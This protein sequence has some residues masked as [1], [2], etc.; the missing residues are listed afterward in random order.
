MII[1]LVRHV[2]DGVVLERTDVPVTFDGGQAQEG[3]VVTF[4]LDGREVHGRIV[5]VLPHDP[6]GEPSI[7]VELIDQDRL[8]D[9]SEIILANLPPKDDFSTDI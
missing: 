5:K 2:G 9:A 3:V 1:N 6:D 8:D 7:E 4:P